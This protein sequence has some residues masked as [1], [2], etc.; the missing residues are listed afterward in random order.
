MSVATIDRL[1]EMATAEP[2]TT[3]R[4]TTYRA[5]RWLPRRGTACLVGSRRVEFTLARAGAAP[6]PVAAPNSRRTRLTAA[7]LAFDVVCLGGF[8]VLVWAIIAGLQPAL[9]MTALV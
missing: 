1:A 7:A 9:Q 2:V 5:R 3:V 4:R 8:A 6:A